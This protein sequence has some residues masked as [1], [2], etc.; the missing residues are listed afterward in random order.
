VKLNFF[1]LGYLLLAIASG[2]AYGF[3]GAVMKKG[4]LEFGAPSSVFDFIRS[5]VTN[6]YIWVSLFCSGS[7]YVL[8]VYILRKT[9]VITTT[10]VIQAVLFLSTSLFAAAMFGETFSPTKVIALVL[11]LGGIAVLLLG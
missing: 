7:G 10:L 9:D 2:I 6:K 11:I 3:G 4:A 8:C 1:S 5:L